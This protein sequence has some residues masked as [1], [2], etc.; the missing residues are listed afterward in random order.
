M[1]YSKQQ[2][3]NNYLLPTIIG[4]GTNSIENSLTTFVRMSLTNYSK[5]SDFAVP[6]VT[7]V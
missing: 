6:G 5:S 7:T 2:V 4:S 1:T 3:I